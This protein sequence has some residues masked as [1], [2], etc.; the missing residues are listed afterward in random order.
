VIECKIHTSFSIVLR[1]EVLSVR[2]CILDLEIGFQR[3]NYFVMGI[4]NTE[5]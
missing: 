2:K 3:K 5:A 1:K 4:V